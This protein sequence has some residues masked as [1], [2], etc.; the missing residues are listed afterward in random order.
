MRDSCRLVCL[1]PD[2]ALLVSDLKVK[3]FAQACL[4]HLAN[5][6]QRSSGYS[7][8][9]AVSKAHLVPSNRIV[10]GRCLCVLD[11]PGQSADRSSK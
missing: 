5:L 2:K 6:L 8:S 11:S 9:T 10:Y 3:S 4:R 1:T 7:L